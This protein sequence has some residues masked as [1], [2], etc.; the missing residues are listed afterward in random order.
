MPF[1]DNQDVVEDILLGFF[2]N[3]GIKN[4]NK[5]L[6]NTTL[7][8]TTFRSITPSSGNIKLPFYLLYIPEDEVMLRNVAN[9]KVVILCSSLIPRFLK[10]MRL[11]ESSILK[12]LKLFFLSSN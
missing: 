1:S 10:T 8:F 6:K 3:L 5:G 4:A 12:L 2:L 9:N 11:R 7:F